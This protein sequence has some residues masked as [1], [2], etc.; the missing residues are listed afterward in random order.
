MSCLVG[1]LLLFNV[2]TGYGFPELEY[3][4]EYKITAYTAGYE[5]TGKTPEHPLYGVTA[6]GVMVQE[7]HTVASD[8]DIHPPGTFL[9]IEGFDTMFKVEDRGGGVRGK[10]LDV[11]IEDLDEALWWGVRNRRVYVLNMKGD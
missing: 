5:S 2:L 7:N 1:L 10:H 4:G 6:T 9:Y 11:Y 8:W 3:V